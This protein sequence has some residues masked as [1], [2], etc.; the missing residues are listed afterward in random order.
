MKKTFSTLL[1]CA[2]FTSAFAGCSQKAV[3]TEEKITDS[4]VSANVTPDTEI[5]DGTI[6]DIQTSEYSVKT[7]D[8]AEKSQTAADNSEVQTK[9]STAAT[10]VET[11]KQ[12]S[13][14]VPT[15]TS[16]PTQEQRPVEVPTTKPHVKTT[17]PPI[18]T[19][20]TAPTQSTEPAFDI[21][22]WVSYAKNYAVSIGLRIDN[23]AVDCWDNPIIANAKCK[24]LERDIK[25]VLNYYARNADI[26][27]VWVWYEEVAQGEYELYI[28]YA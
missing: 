15:T 11:T 19:R 8:S 22:Y 13:N 5:S 1:V 28:G 16:P 12:P 3:T 14:T 6:A 21:T 20:P 18:T 9:V 4:T 27:D 2:M 24:Y 25:G 7:T 10:A 23:S 26:T 17:S